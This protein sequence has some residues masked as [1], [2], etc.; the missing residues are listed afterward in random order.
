[1]V[2]CVSVLLSYGEVGILRVVV[3][4]EGVCLFFSLSITVV[5]IYCLFFCSST[6]QILAARIIDGDLAT[7]RRV[8]FQSTGVSSMC[9]GRRKCGC[10][11]FIGGLSSIRL[12]DGLIRNSSSMLIVISSEC[13]LPS[14]RRLLDLSTSMFPFVLASDRRSTSFI[15][16]YI[17]GSSL[18][19]C[20]LG[21]R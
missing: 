17:I 16:S 7:S 3:V 14:Y 10:F 9:E 19:H 12:S 5:T 21:G 18:C 8:C 15:I 13:G 1:M 2:C 11:Q 6:I 20:Q 4:G